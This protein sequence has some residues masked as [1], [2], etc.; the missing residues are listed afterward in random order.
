MRYRIEISAE[1]REQWRA[2]TKELRR[3]IGMRMEM[4]AR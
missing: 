3:N 1:A 4:M 2:M